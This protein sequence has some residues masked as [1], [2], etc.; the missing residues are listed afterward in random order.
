[1]SYATGTNERLREV[2][3]DLMG[4]LFA[5]RDPKTGER[6]QFKLKRGQNTYAYLPDRILCP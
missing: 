6:I 3:A 2:M 4:D 1:V 5:M